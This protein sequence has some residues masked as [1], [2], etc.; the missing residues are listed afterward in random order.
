MLIN[1]NHN[2]VLLGLVSFFTDLG[3]YMVYPLIPL[4]LASMGA[5]P[6]IIGVIEGISESLTSLLKL[7]SG[8]WS[9]RLNKRKQISIFG[10]GIS[11]FGRLFLILAGSWVGVFLWRLIDRLGK[12]IRTAPR[13]ALISESSH[14]DRHG[15]SFG[16]HQTLDMLGAAIGIGIAYVLMAGD[17]ADYGW[18]FLYSMFPVM[19]GFG[20]LFLIDDSG[21]PK[22]QQAGAQQKKL[23]K[24]RWK[25]LDPKIKRLMAV[26]FLFTL[27][28]SSNQFLIL[29]ASEAGISTSNVL[30]LYLLFNIAAALLSFPA[31]RLSD[32]AGRKGVLT[33]GY[34][35]YGLT[36]IGFGVMHSIQGYWLLFALYGIY[37]GLTKGVEKALIADISPPEFRAT[38]LGA[39]S[40]FVGVGLLPASIITGW[41][42]DRFGASA[43][44]Y[45]SGGLAL[46]TAGLLCLVLAGGPRSVEQI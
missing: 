3:T 18:L 15:R 7:F 28:N 44:F 29:R 4:F 5:T 38:T 12:G 13:D 24:F 1:K 6:L 34:L 26:I 22:P 23:V 36:Y 45:F 35:L 20:I 43:P 9:D 16:F 41:L 19:V 42:W 40:M 39:Y 32:I 25:D 2:V 33:A 10:Y 30:L 37:T 27:A 17:M 8:V 31:G 14:V 11:L 46:L 21:V